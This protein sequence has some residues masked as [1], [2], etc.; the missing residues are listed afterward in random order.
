ME[1]ICEGY[2]DMLMAKLLQEIKRHGQFDFGLVFL[3]MDPGY[4]EKISDSK[5]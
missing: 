1:K 3:S 2:S 5:N 4:N